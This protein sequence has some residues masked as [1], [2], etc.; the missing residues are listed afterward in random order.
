MHEMC[1]NVFLMHWAWSG[2]PTVMTALTGRYMQGMFYQMIQAPRPKQSFVLLCLLPPCLNG[3]GPWKEISN[4][5]WSISYSIVLFFCNIFWRE[6]DKHMNRI[7]EKEGE[8]KMLKKS[9]PILF[10]FVLVYN[11]KDFSLL[12]CYRHTICVGVMMCAFSVMAIMLKCLLWTHSAWRLCL[13]WHQ[14]LTLTGSVHYM[15]YGRQ[16]GKVSLVACF[17]V[18]AQ[19]HLHE[20]QN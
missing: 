1:H 6:G 18:V 3:S 2:Y 12:A 20:I 5:T 16:R 17:I 15:F 19:T 14:E 8:E 11:N 7:K 10:I 4:D 9:F 13:L